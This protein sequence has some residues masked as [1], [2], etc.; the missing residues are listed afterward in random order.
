MKALCPFVFILFALHFA[1]TKMFE[2]I[3]LKQGRF[4]GPWFQRLQFLVVWLVLS[5]GVCVEA[6]RSGTQLA[7]EGEQRKEG[8][9]EAKSD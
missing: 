8:G 3:Y 5:L 7:V 1:L 9:W 4:S 2:K 6:W